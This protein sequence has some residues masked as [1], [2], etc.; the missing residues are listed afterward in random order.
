MKNLKGI[1]WFQEFILLDI[2]PFHIEEDGLIYCGDCLNILPKLPI[3]KINLVCVD[4]P[5]NI[6]SPQL[7]TDMRRKD[8][9]KIGK[10]FGSFDKEAISPEEWFPYMLNL[11]LSFYNNRKI[12]KLIIAAEN[13][14]YEVLQSF[15]WCKTNP[16]VPMRKV[17]FAWGTETGY[18]FKKI[19][20]KHSFNINAGISPN[21]FQDSLCSGDERT[22]HPT[23]KKLSV[24]KWLIAHWSFPGDIVLDFALGSGT[25]AIAAKQLGRRFIGIEINEEYCRMAV[26]RLWGFAIEPD[27]TKRKGIFF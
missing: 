21:W 23:Q 1:K 19:G 24:I 10:D 15:H 27:E 20:V 4:P 22:S 9:R 17:G 5:Y 2:K 25:T 14:G 12:H 3:N 18:V 6:G 13:N 11:V 7:I 16:P 26:N 8:R